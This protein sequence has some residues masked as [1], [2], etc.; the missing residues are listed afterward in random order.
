MARLARWPRTG[1][2]LVYAGLAL[3][4]FGLPVAAHPSSQCITAAAGPVAAYNLL[5]PTLAA[6]TAFLLCR[7][8]TG[9]WLPSLVG[10]YL[11]GFSSYEIGQ[12]FGHPNLTLVFLLPVMVHLVLRRVDGEL[13]VGRFVAAMAACVVAQALLSPEIAVMFSLFGAVALALGA[14]VLDTRRRAIVGLVWP[15]A[16]AYLANHRVK[17]VI[18]DPAHDDGWLPVLARV[19]LTPHRRDGVLVYPVSGARP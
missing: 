10:G 9:K 11:F 2:F 18:L 16:I 4:F 14:L 13:P 1:A 19:G 12:L 6:F 5:A 3:V 15:L 7:R 17:V 8:I